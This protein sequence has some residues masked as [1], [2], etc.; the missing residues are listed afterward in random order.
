LVSEVQTADLVQ[1]LAPV[2]EIRV[3]LEDRE[4]GLAFRRI[5]LQAP[6]LIDEIIE[7]RPKIVDDV[8]N[9]EASHYLGPRGERMSDRLTLFEV[10]IGV[11]VV[12]FSVKRCVVAA[13]F[14]Q[15]HLR[16]LELPAEELLPQPSIHR[17]TST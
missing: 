10:E 17:V 6:E 2:E 15:M 16:P 9:H 4:L 13:E 8:A 1:S 14:L 12:R 5:V 3:A 11:D 7:C